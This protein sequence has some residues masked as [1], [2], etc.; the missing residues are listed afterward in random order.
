M[1]WGSHRQAKLEAGPVHRFINRI[2]GDPNAVDGPEIGCGSPGA[3][4]ELCI[5]VKDNDLNLYCLVEACA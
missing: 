5:N 1:K 3:Q 4:L 2:G